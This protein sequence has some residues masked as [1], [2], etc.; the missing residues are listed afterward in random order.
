MRNTISILGV[1]VISSL[2]LISCGGSSSDGT[3]SLTKNGIAYP[4]CELGVGEF[5]GC[6]ISEV[7]AI[8]ESGAVKSTRL[9]EQVVET[10]THPV[11]SGVINKYH[12]RYEDDQCAGDPVEI[13]NVHD[14]IIEHT[15]AEITWGYVQ[16]VDVECS[17]TGGTSSL[18]CNAM[19]IKT[20]SVFGETTGLTTQL[21]A[22]DRL[23]MPSV[24]YIFGSTG[25]T[26]IKIGRAHV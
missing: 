21:I 26:G 12:L 11:V 8:D 25:D 23:C 16:Q 22:S 5:A 24:D 10:S 9:I 4:S 14:V 2:A 18:L 7:C 3:G 19:D 17:E 15:G 6:W 13:V 1:T 20:T